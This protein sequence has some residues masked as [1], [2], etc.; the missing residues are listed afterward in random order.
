MPYAGLPS[1]M[2]RKPNVH[3]LVGMLQVAHAYLQAEST[4]AGRL[5]DNTTV[6]QVNVHYNLQLQCT[7]ITLVLQTKQSQD[8][9]HAHS[10]L[11]IC[12]LRA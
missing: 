3:N 8:Q 10:N 6:S 2:R 11:S 9:M 7:Q 1:S 5:D 4:P 12:S